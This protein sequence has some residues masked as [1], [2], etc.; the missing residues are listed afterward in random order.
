MQF[1]VGH[2][3]HRPGFYRL[4]AVAGELGGEFGFVGRQDIALGQQAGRQIGI[5]RCGVEQRRDAFVAGQVETGK[6]GVDRRFQLRQH[7]PRIGE[8]VTLRPNVGGCH[9]RVGA[10]TD[11]DA[12]ASFPVDIDA[13]GAGGMRAGGV[14]QDDAVD[15]RQCAGQLSAGIGAERADE[16]GH[17]ARAC[18]GGGLV[19]A[20]AAGAGAVFALERLAGAW[21]HRQRPH[22]VDVERADHNH[23]AHRRVPVSRRGRS[24]RRRS[25]R[26]SGSRWCR[27][28]RPAGRSGRGPGGGR[29]R[30]RRCRRSGS[31]SN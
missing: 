21:Q 29:A 24:A 17:G 2:S 28:A 16:G 14:A 19:E 26:S 11:D 5:G 18:G 4:A 30:A 31:R 7:H 13:G 12:V 27:R 10:G 6:H 23:R 20:L 9:G 1:G 22:V 8:H 15:A 3:R 25:S